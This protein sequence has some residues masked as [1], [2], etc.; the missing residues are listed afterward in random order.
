VRRLG[1]RIGE[2]VVRK[3]ALA[4]FQHMSRDDA[5]TSDALLSARRA[6]QLSIHKWVND[7]V[8]HLSPEAFQT[9]LSHLESD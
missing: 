9:Y 2:S 7:H 4:L 3:E 6:V 1:G 8:D 5:V